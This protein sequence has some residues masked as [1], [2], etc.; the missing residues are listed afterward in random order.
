MSEGTLWGALGSFFRGGAKG[1]IP[2]ALGG[3]LLALAVSWYTCSQW[4]FSIGFLVAP[5]AAGAS[6]VVGVVAGFHVRA[7]VGLWHDGFRSLAPFA[8]LPAVVIVT[9][10][11]VGWVHHDA[12]VKA[13]ARDWHELIAL[14]TDD[15]GTAQFLARLRTPRGVEIVRDHLEQ[16]LVCASLSP[17]PEV[18]DSVA[19]LDPRGK[20]GYALCSVAA[21]GEPTLV[22]H[23][24]DEGFDPRA[25]HYSDGRSCS[26]LRELANAGSAPDSCQQYSALPQV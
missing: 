24:L 6:I 9:F 13:Y 1:I 26:P 20:H 10:A 19:R 16:F 15:G 2:G 14:E 8:P 11:Y 12:S 5:V 25:G 23:V 3:C 17:D 22:K 21:Y 4:Y 7:V 18:I